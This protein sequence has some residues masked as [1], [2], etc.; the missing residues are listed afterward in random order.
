VIIVYCEK[1]TGW[2]PISYMVRLAAKLLEAELIIVKYKGLNIRDKLSALFLKR[3]S[4]N[5]GEKLLLICSSP[6]DL[7]LIFQIENFKY[8]FDY[9]AAWVIDSF[10]VDRIPKFVRVSGYFDHIFITSAEDIEEWEQ[11]TKTPISW[12]PWASDVL[13]LGG[14]K[15]ERK[16]DLIRVGRQP[17][18][19][20]DDDIT[21]KRCM[22]NNISFSGRPD[23][24]EDQLRNQLSLMEYYQQA[25]FVLAFSN[26][27]SPGSYTHPVRAYLTARWVDTL[28]CGGVV[29][30]MSP[31]EPSIQKLLWDGATLE[32][33]T[34]NI[35]AGMSSMVDALE[36]WSPSHA[37]YNYT[38]S[39][40]RLD[41][42]WRF[43]EIAN[44]FDL[45][46]NLLFS[47]IKLLE[48]E[49]KKNS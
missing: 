15:K 33:D 47:D 43:V 35:D 36:R 10:W 38:Q 25:K 23:F 41:W 19:W 30:G 46:P 12:L 32:F 26:I 14:S 44:L 6:T 8:R 48:S 1:K 18:E 3:K 29:A 2:A 24:F 27:E 28:A 17:I 7:S 4:A 42:R 39:L 16:W 40:R 31:K 9:I 45:S 20:D 22:D 5:G 21:Y 34:V 13:T 37:S 49:I 11:I